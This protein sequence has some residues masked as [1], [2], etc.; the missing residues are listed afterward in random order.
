MDISNNPD[1]TSFQFIEMIG[2]CF[3]D[4]PFSEGS[5]MLQ[6]EKLTRLQKVCTR[7]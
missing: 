7:A 2:D 1:E 5:F 4:R 6:D 3:C